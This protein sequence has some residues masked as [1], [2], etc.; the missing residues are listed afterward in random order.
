[1][2]CIGKF[3]QIPSRCV[4]IDVFLNG[5][6]LQVVGGELIIQGI[7]NDAFGMSEFCQ[8]LI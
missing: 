2:I 7:V 6:I 5:H 4:S 3:A 8:L 1:M